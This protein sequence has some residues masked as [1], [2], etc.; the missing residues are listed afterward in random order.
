[1][2]VISISITESPTQI[3]AGI[4]KTI[5]LAASIASSIFYTLDGSDPNLFSEIYTGPISMPT[6][7]LSVT[8]KVFASNGVDN[9]PIISE[10]YFTNEVNGNARLAR[11]GTDARA[12]ARIKDLYPYGTNPI[13]PTTQ[14]TN[15]GDV[16]INVNDPSLPSAPT[17][18]DGTGQPTGYTNK[19]YN[20]Q[21][22][23]IIYPEGN[24]INEP[25]VVGQLPSK[26]TTRPRPDIP[27]S[28]DYSSKYFD[29]KAFVIY[30]DASTEDPSKPPLINRMHFTGELHEKVRTGNNFFVSGLDAPPTTGSFVRSSYNAREN[31]MTYYYYD[32]IANKWIISKQPYQPKDPDAGALYQVKFAR[33]GQT[34]GVVFSWIP[35]ARRV[36]F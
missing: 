24:S 25:L 27:E 33:G 31:T 17:G 19:P 7:F 36:L 15:P 14:F 6:E 18:Y 5:T 4:P 32:Q 12:N 28:T 21:N 22:Y 11:H 10:T 2:A 23:D 34:A 3:V 9:S 29:P 35:F 30:Q 26:I 8:L 16:G 13:E 1:M 20:F